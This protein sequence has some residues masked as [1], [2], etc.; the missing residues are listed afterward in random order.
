MWHWE[1]R[2]VRKLAAKELILYLKLW[3]TCLHW[4]SSLYL[5]YICL[6]KPWE[7]IR[8]YQ[9]FVQGQGNPPQVLKI[10]S[11]RCNSL[12]QEWISLSLYEVVST[13]YMFDKALGDYKNLP[14]LCTGTGKSIL[15]SKICSGRC[16]SLTQGWI[17]LYLYKVVVDYFSPTTLNPPEK[18]TFMLSKYTLKLFLLRKWCQLELI[19]TSHHC[20]TYD[21]TRWS[22]KPSGL[23][24]GRYR[25]LGKDSI[26]NSTGNTGKTLSE[27]GEKENLSRVHGEDRESWTQGMI[28]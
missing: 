16:N 3:H 14:R 8:I 6:I 22:L 13:L 20:M 2:I 25:Q 10:C 17:S 26:F 4:H 1:N 23:S 5:L 21:V 18:K 24:Q 15:V 12:T 27:V 11:G 7:T 19:M 9:D 28:C